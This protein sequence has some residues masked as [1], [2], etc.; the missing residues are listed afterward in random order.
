[1]RTYGQT[2]GSPMSAPTSCMIEP[3]LA[4]RKVTCVSAITAQASTKIQDRRNT[5]GQLARAQ[6]AM[7]NTTGPVAR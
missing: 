1:M 6:Q 5:T 2:L 4:A 7:R 3:G